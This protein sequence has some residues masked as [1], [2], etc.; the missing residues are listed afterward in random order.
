MPLLELEEKSIRMARKIIIDNNVILDEDD[1]VPV[2]ISRDIVS[3]G[4]EHPAPKTHDLPEG[5]SHFWQKTFGS[6]PFPAEQPNAAEV[7]GGSLGKDLE[8][9]ASEM[10]LA[11]EQA[12]RD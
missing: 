3:G 8:L 6:E 7:F 4:S 11:I 9:T 1:Y 10:R 2:S 5:R 12:D